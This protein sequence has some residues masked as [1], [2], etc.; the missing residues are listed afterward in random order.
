MGILLGKKLPEDVVIPGMASLPE[1]NEVCKSAIETAVHWLDS[2]PLLEP[3]EFRASGRPI[4]DGAYLVANKSAQM[5]ITHL[6][7]T[8]PEL[9]KIK[10]E[11]VK[12]IFDVIMSNLLVA[13]GSWDSYLALLREEAAKEKKLSDLINLLVEKDLCMFVSTDSSNEYY[14]IADNVSQAVAFLKEHELPHRIVNG[15]RLAKMKPMWPVVPKALAIIDADGSQ[16]AREAYHEEEDED[17]PTEGL[18]KVP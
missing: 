4:G 7:D 10:P 18:I 2:Q 13:V 17:L 12:L 1:A 3:P 16:F 11:F 8:H 15:G 6:V 14:V 9:A 5:L